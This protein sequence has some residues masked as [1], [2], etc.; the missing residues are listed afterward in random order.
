MK[1]KD[2]VWIAVALLTLVV[3]SCGEK[4]EVLPT[5]SESQVVGHWKRTDAN[6]AWFLEADHTG[7]YYWDDIDELDID[8]SW[9]HAS[10]ELEDGVLTVVD[11]GSVGN[12]AVPKSYTI[13][14]ISSSAMR[15]RDEYHTVISL[16]RI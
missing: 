11:S 12:Q 8:A 7:R 9:H 10:W 16:R 2:I 6:R 3:G 15:W 5:V 13:T 4:E 1:R 14:E